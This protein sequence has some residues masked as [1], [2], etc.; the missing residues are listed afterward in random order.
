MNEVSCRAV[1]MFFQE[2]QRKGIPSSML[3]EGVDYSIQ[4]LQNKN[5]RIDW[6][7]LIRICKNA[8]RIWTEEELLAI[9]AAFLRSPYV[10]WTL[11]VA[12]LLFTEKDFY[13]WQYS[14]NKHGPSKQFVSCVTAGFEELSETRFRLTLDTDDGYEGFPRSFALVSKGVLIET[15]RVLGGRSAKVQDFVTPKGVEFIVE[16]TPRSNLIR[17]LHRALVGP[18][19]ILAAGR[20][21]K[22]ANELLQERY[23]QLEEAHRVL[24]R[25]LTALKTAH[26]VNN[27][28]RGELELIP[29]LETVA[30]AIVKVGGVRGARITV[31]D[32]IEG[33]QLEHSYSHGETPEDVKPVTVPLAIGERTIGIMHL[34]PA[35]SDIGE[36]KELL[37]YVTPTVAVALDDALKFTSLVDLRKTLESKVTVRTE[38]L[39]RMSETLSLTVEQ[40]RQSQSARNRFFANI[41]HEFRTPL[42]LIEGPASQILTG[43]IDP[44]ENAEIIVRNTRRLLALVNQLLDLSKIESGEMQLQKRTID[45]VDVVRGIAASFESLAKRKEIDFRTEHPDKP[46]FGSF[47]T[48]AIEKIITNLLSNAFKFTLGGGIVRLSICS[49]QQPNHAVTLKVSD[50]GIGIAP[51]QIDKIFDRFY[52]V[53]QS[54]TRE[55]EGTGIGLALTKELVELHKGDIVASSELGKGTAITVHLPLGIREFQAEVATAPSVQH[56]TPIVSDLSHLSEARLEPADNSLPLVLIIEDNADMRHYMR[57]YLDDFRVIEAANGEEGVEKAVE[58]IPDLII[59][60]VMMPKMDGFALSEKLKTDERTSHIPVI[61]LTAKAGKEHRIEGLETGADDYVTKPFEPKELQVR[62][63]NLIEQRKKLREKFRKEGTFRLKE[64]A[65]TTAD[66]RFLN[67]AM[68]VIEA[69]LAD[70]TFT[71]ESFAEEMYVSRMQLHRKIRALTDLSPWQFVR[72]VRL[73]RAADLLRKRVGNVSD[74]AYQIGY[75][76]PSRFAEAFREEFGKTPSEFAFPLTS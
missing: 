28:V 22:E 49:H 68:E 13:R 20:E 4:H 30:A 46:I 10:R 36:L 38:E 23:E 26:A 19:S 61:L 44:K 9:G 32:D 76:S 27:A 67:R 63:K 18:F 25:Q 33:K 59:S 1:N 71:S 5:G 39:Q 47:D 34:W 7:T 45:I 48:D 66:E 74:I 75:D 53:D 21:L 65:I 35:D 17:R 42:T 24:D 55:Y 11:L 62:I 58:T 50:T 40:L 41:S 57:T 69:H 8:E 14:P 72:K 3:L 54:Q 37:Q 2:L 64:I 51:K 60:D 29:A 12:R 6:P 73:H 56:R 70:Q 52:Q 31:R 15:P 16:I 43:E